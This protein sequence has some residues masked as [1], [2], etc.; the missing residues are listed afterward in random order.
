MR[1]EHSF[2]VPWPKARFWNERQF[3]KFVQAR[4]REVVT[5]LARGPQDLGTDERRTSLMTPPKPGRARGACA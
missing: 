1:R 2:G 3:L 4:D 5:V